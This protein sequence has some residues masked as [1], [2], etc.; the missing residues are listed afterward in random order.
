MQPVEWFVL[1]IGGPSGVGK[2]T[3]APAVAKRFDATWLQV[4]D[5]ALAIERVGLPFPD[6]DSVPLFDARGGLLDRA[7][8]L[9]PAIEVVIEN[10]VDQGQRVVLEGD[11]IL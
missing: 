1:L 2:T 10:H 7:Y 5:L 9:T 8:L 6:A 11:A 3:I 4:D